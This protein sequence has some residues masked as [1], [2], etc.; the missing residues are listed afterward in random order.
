MVKWPLKAEHFN[1]ISVQDIDDIYIHLKTSNSQ[2]EYPSVK[3]I[4][5]LHLPGRTASPAGDSLAG[6]ANGVTDT[7]AT[8]QGEKF[9]S[10]R[11]NDAVKDAVHAN[12][13]ECQLW[14][15]SAGI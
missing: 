14:C 6:V 10:R 7:P 4:A 15:T 8:T 13:C 3:L 9:Q 12:W 11:I 5:I 1:K 2:N